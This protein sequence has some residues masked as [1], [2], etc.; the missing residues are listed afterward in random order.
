MTELIMGLALAF[1]IL[2]IIWKWKHRGF[3]DGTADA[4]LL[5]LVMF[6]AGS[7]LTGM[8]VGT[9]ASAVVSGYLLVDP[10]DIKI[11]KLRLPKIRLPRFGRSKHASV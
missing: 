6:I 9:I 11:P 10:I 5:G 2:V 7:S 1:N 4:V 3:V 8:L